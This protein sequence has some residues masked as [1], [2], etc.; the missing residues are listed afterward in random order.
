MKDVQHVELTG[1]HPRENKASSGAM[2]GISACRQIISSRGGGQ[3]RGRVQKKIHK[4]R[5]KSVRRGNKVKKTLA[6]GFMQQGKKTQYQGQGHV[7]S[8]GPRTVRKRRET[9]DVEEMQ[10]GHFAE[11]Q[12]RR[13]LDGI[14]ISHSHSHSPNKANDKWVEETGKI[15]DAGAVNCNSME[16]IESDDSA[17][18]TRYRHLKVEPQFGA[19]S[20][21]STRDMVE[22]SDDDADVNDVHDYEDD[23]NIDDEIM[24]DGSHGNNVESLETSGDYSDSSGME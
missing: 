16:A 11:L 8:H 22:T 6:P 2:R 12:E 10:M 9:I 21:R 13:T 3:P 5:S 15:Q 19:A 17:D 23:N 14:G 24:N 18:A 20:D 7:Y 1:I 4:S